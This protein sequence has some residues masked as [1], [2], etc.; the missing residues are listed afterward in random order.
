V[1]RGY[2]LGDRR[3]RHQ[4]AQVQSP[5]RGRPRVDEPAMAHRALGSQ[6]LSVGLVFGA[7]LNV[8]LTSQDR[9][10]AWRLDSCACRLWG[11]SII[12]AAPPGQGGL[13]RLGFDFTKG[14]RVNSCSSPSSCTTERRRTAPPAAHR[15]ST[16]TC[17]G[18]CAYPA[19]PPP[20]VPLVQARPAGSASTRAPRY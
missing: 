16:S 2:W 11:Q 18:P 13:Q 4:R 3:G 5:A 17:D 6:P 9:R 12:A 19:R 7:D 14:L 8:L 15:Q 1:D 20:R 10:D